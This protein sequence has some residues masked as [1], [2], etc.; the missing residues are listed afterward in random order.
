MLAM[1][2]LRVD[3]TVII[4]HGFLGRRSSVMPLLEF[5]SHVDINDGFVFPSVT[6]GDNMRRLEHFLLVM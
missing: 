2:D 5:M 4:T 3:L 6:Y 1:S